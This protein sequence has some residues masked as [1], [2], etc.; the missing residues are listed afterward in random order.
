M[1]CN[2]SAFEKTTRV[3]KLIFY[4]QPMCNVTKLIRYVTDPFKVQ[5][6]KGVLI[7]GNKTF[8]EMVPDF[9]LQLSLKKVSHVN[10]CCRIKEECM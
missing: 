2:T 6:V 7:E 5:D 8:I 1:N 10:F 4:E 9:T 3:S